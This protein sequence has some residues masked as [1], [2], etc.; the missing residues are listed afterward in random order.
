MYRQAHRARAA[1]LV[2]ALTSLALSTGCGAFSDYNGETED[3]RFAFEQGDFRTAVAEFSEELDA[4]NHE[5]LFH[6]EAAL[7]A[8]VGGNYMQS[9]K[10]FDEAYKIVAQY[11]DRAMISA[12]DVAETVGSFLVNEKTI[13]YTGAVFEQLMLQNSPD[14]IQGSLEHLARE[15]ESLRRI[16]ILNNEGRIAYSS[17]PQEVGT[18]LN[19]QDRSCPGAQGPP[20]GHVRSRLHIV[21]YLYR[22]Q[23]VAGG[24]GIH[25]PSGWSRRH[26]D[27]VQGS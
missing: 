4:D 16:F 11:Q 6:M 19:R 22:F 23:Q 3:A 21:P 1:W 26:R 24:A 15:N 25:G 10:L 20:P 13:P 9:F 18:L 12:S 27:L 2:T 7:S 8:H 14:A 17:D 5:L